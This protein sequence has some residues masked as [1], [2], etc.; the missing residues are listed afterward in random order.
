MGDRHT[1][2][3]QNFQTHAENMFLPNRKRS[4][5]NATAVQSKNSTI[6]LHKQNFKWSS[7]K[8]EQIIRQIN[9]SSIQRYISFI[10]Y[11]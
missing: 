8:K 11:H 9:V 3:S 6:C 4:K 5:N 7:S 2:H 10:S 1:Y